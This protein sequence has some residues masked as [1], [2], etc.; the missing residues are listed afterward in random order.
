[1]NANHRQPDES[2]NVDELPQ[3]RAAD[4]LSTYSNHVEIGFSPWDFKFLIFE[5]TEGEDGEIIREKK[6][7]VVMSPQHAVAFSRVLKSTVERWE[8]EHGSGRQAR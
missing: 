5:V 1:M 8:K 7:R 3:Q 4:Y 6:A 2:V